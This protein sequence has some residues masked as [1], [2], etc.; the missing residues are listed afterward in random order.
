MLNTH[1]DYFLQC[2]H[3]FLEENWASLVGGGIT[4]MT[5]KGP[6]LNSDQCQCA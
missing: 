4:L 1:H 5:P 2:V 6:L 3:C